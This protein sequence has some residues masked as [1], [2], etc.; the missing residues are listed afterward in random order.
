M[1][2]SFLHEKDPILKNNPIFKSVAPTTPKL[3]NQQLNIPS[4]L[5]K[6]DNTPKLKISEVLVVNIRI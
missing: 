3:Q 1:K 5:E 6:I 4:L 2:K